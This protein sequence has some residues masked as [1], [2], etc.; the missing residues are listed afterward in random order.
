MILV[1]G[2][3]LAAALGASLLAGRLRVPGLVAFLGIGMAVG[4]DGFGWI[5]FSDYELERNIGIVALG[6]DPVRGRPGDRA[7]TSCGPSPGPRSSLAIVG[8]ILTAVITGLAA[9]W[10]FDFTLAAGRCSSARSWPAPTAPRSSRCC[11]ARRS[12]AGWRRRSRA[13]P[14]IN[15]PVAVILVLGVRSHWLQNPDYG[16]ED[17]ALLFVQELSIGAVVGVAVGSPRAAACS[18]CGSARPACTRS[19]RSPR[20]R[21]AYGARR[22]RS[23]ARAS[24]RSTC[25]ALLL[26]SS[27]IPAR[28]TIVTFHEGLAWVAQLGMFLTLGLLV[29]PSELADVALEGTVIALVA[30]AVARPLARRR[31]AA[32][33]RLSRSASG[34]SLGWAGLRGAVPVVLATFPVI[35]GV[36]QGQTIFNIVFFAVVVSTVLQGATF[37]P[38]AHWLGVTTDEQALPAPLLEP[39]AVRRLG[40]EVAQ[41]AVGARR[42]GRGPSG[43]RPRAAAR[44]AAEPDRPRRAGDPAARLDGRR[45]PATTCTCWCA[46]RP[47]TDFGKLMRRWRDGPMPSARRAPV[48]TRAVSIFSTGR[49]M[50]VDGDPGAPGAREGPRRDRPGAHAPRRAG[51]AR[52]RSP[53]GASPTRGRSRRSAR[54]A[55]FRTRPASGSRSA[56]TDAE[57]AW[58]REVIGALEGEWGL[59]G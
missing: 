8:T 50:A 15:D 6:A 16:I 5:D 14:G 29:F 13:R 30:A 55:S 36:A 43:A 41:F 44:R 47:S 28:R 4:S 12:S 53:T 24:W 23:T 57:R 42:R 27:D 11:A 20:P 7:S 58:W 3:L 1:A 35:D 54:R 19:R 38:F 59:M 37:E 33:R 25:A 48:G 49:R 9:W 21:I 56:K 10:L 2:A 18:A 40:A 26:G 39:G 46:R 52:R 34:S 31:G 32:V 51:R 17:M 22:R 45:R